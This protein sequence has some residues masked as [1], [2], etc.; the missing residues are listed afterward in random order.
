MNV[1]R[2]K[3]G[4]KN[5][6][7]TYEA[8]LDYEYSASFEKKITSLILYR[9]DM[10]RR[11]SIPWKAFEQFTQPGT[12]GAYADSTGLKVRYADGG[13]EVSNGQNFSVKIQPDQAAAIKRAA[14]NISQ[15]VSCSVENILREYISHSI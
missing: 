14:R 5:W 2:F 7:T 13:L 15:D 4:Y 3:K 9:P 11:V 10:G 8:E 6:E 1:L 12:G